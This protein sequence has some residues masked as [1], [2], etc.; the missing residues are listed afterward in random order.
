M[1]D[2][3][4]NFREYWTI[5]D[6]PIKFCYWNGDGEICFR[7]F[8]IGCYVS[9]NSQTSKICNRLAVENDTFYMFNHLDFEIMY[10]SQAKFANRIVGVKVQVNRSVRSIYYRRLFFECFIV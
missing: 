9:N 3:A 6:M 10:H 5:D 4:F 8:Q 2:I 7:S 1:E